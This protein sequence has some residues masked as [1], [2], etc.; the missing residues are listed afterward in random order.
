MYRGSV[1]EGLAR[2]TVR[3]VGIVGDPCGMLSRSLPVC[4]ACRPVGM[5]GGLSV[6][7]WSRL[8]MSPC[9]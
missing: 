9:P 3:D 5:C 6:W 2:V 4:G 7:L 1:G 8:Q